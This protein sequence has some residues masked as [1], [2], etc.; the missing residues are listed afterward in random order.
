MVLLLVVDDRPLEV[1]REDVPHDPYR[2]V[3][4]LKDERRR[5]RL[6]HAA[7]EDLV[8]LVQVL[9]LAFEVRPLGPVGGR[10]YDR[11][12]APEV[13]LGGLAAQPLAF[14]ILEAPRDPDAVARGRVDA[15]SA[16]RSSAPS[17]GG[18]PWS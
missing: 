5:G 13:E 2:Q 6:L 10:A 14:A 3:R 1:L 18:L 16:R 7:I 15:D 4:L 8:E 12:A 17:T 11:P 9:E